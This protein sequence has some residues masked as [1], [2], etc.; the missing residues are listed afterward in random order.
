[1]TFN[2][3]LK[4]YKMNLK[5]MNEITRRQ[6]VK[7]SALASL[8][9]ASTVKTLGAGGEMDEKHLTDQD[10][11]DTSHPTTFIFAAQF[12]REPSYPNSELKHD[13][14]AIKLEGR[15]D[16]TSPVTVPPFSAKCLILNEKL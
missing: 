2:S 13:M 11:R 16:V 8:S 14:L 12:F 7:E 5:K 1:M 3:G 9:I 15:F 10:I 4:I 6:F